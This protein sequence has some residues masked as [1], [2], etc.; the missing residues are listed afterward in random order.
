MSG[1]YRRV[2]FHSTLQSSFQSF[3]NRPYYQMASSLPIASAVVPPV[4]TSASLP[5]PVVPES[6]G[7]HCPE[8]VVEGRLLDKDKRHEIYGKVSGGADSMKLERFQ[9][10]MIEKGTGLPCAK[11]DKRI[12]LRTKVLK[13]VPH[14][15][16]L[17]DGFD[18]SEDFDGLQIFKGIEVLINLKCIVGKGG[19]QTRS[20]REV[21]WFV[22]GQFHVL[23]TNPTVC[24]ANIL[25]G[26]ESHAVLP[27]FE[28]LASLPEF[29]ALKPRIYIGD[30]K[31]YFEWATKTFY[32]A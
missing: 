29:A 19:G 6:L 8:S 20:L 32:A 2:Y 4:N 7:V 28:Y 12:N 15:N 18:Y 11:T 10:D 30:L 5:T 24:F 26:D 21:Y 22:E 14:P 1:V 25:D 3:F 31:G 23:K 13:D 27:K 16:K 17:I 9:R